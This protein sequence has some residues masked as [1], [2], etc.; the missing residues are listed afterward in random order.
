VVQSTKQVLRECPIR[1]VAGVIVCWHPE[2]I[3][4]KFRTSFCP[5]FWQE[6]FKTFLT[7]AD[8]MTGCSHVFS[9]QNQV[10]G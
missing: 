8:R 7:V 5:S 10:R 6:N 9:N 1:L 3:L 2:E 4:V